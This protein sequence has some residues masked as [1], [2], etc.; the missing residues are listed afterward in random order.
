M[1]L[2]YDNRKELTQITED[3]ELIIDERVTYI[4]YNTFKKQTGDYEGGYYR[5]KYVDQENDTVKKVRI[6]DGVTYIYGGLFE[7]I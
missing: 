3:G 1:D 7:R 2:D 5:K 6:P 4:S